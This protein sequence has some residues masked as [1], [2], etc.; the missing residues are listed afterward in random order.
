MLEEIGEI[1]FVNIN[2]QLKNR[3]AAYSKRSF[4][5]LRTTEPTR[6]AVGLVFAHCSRLLAQTARCSACKNPGRQND[7]QDRFASP[8][9]SLRRIAVHINRLKILSG[10]KHK[11]AVGL[12]FA[13]CSRLLA[14]TA[15]RSACKNA[16]RQNDSQD[17][18]ASPFKSLRTNNTKYKAG[19]L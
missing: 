9:E 5:S 12:V 16:G 6:P 17:R 8:F 19:C 11:P 3:N 18:F 14:Q 15:R 2:R 1:A 13:H 10:W 4:E 7:S